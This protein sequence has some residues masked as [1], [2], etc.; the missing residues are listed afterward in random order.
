MRQEVEEVVHAGDAFRR[1]RRDAC[2]I[3]WLQQAR[4]PASRGSTGESSAQADGVIAQSNEVA[5]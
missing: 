4:L 5:C 3:K 2:S 1:S